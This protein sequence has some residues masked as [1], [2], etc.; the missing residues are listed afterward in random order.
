MSRKQEQHELDDLLIHYG[1]KSMK[2]GVRRPPSQLF[3][4][5]G[6]GGG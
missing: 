4:S 5:E 1:I 6:G 3:K 2:L